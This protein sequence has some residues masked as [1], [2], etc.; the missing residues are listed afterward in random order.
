MTNS[1]PGTNLVMIVDELQADPG[2]THLSID[3]AARPGEQETTDLRPGAMACETVK[4]GSRS[5][6]IYHRYAPELRGTGPTFMDAI[7]NLYHAMDRASDGIV[8]SLHR[9]L[10]MAAFQDLHAL[11]GNPR[12][13]WPVFGTTTTSEPLLVVKDNAIYQLWIT[14]DPP[15]ASSGRQTVRQLEDSQWLVTRFIRN[16]DGAPRAGPARDR[17]GSLRPGKDRRCVDR[18]ASHLAG[19]PVTSAWKLSLDDQLATSG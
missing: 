17:R 10:L 12:S 11:L 5:I 16:L 4:S 8:E 14:D 19:L 1:I 9:S 15:P 6:Q 2:A 3:D 18:W 7:L 13:D